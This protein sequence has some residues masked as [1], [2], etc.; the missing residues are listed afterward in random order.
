MTSHGYGTSTYPTKFWLNT[1]HDSL[2]GMTPSQALND[3]TP[4]NIHTY[5]VRSS[6][7]AS[8]NKTLTVHSK[9]LGQVKEPHDTTQQHM[10]SQ[11]NR[12]GKLALC[13][14][15]HLLPCYYAKSILPQMRKITLWSF[16]SHNMNQHCVISP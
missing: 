5:L 11:A 3:H 13:E 12:G 2:I 10:A 4:L 16:Q 14:V 9:L 6:H 7:V 8:I 15:T 1:T